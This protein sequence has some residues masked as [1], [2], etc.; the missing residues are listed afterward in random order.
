MAES[1]TD[2]CK[3]LVTMLLDYPAVLKTLEE[4]AFKYI[5]GKGK[6]CG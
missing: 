6:K 1:S 5:M 3:R 4:K 2:V